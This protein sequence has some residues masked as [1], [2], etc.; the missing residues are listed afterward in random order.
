M[1]RETAVVL[2]GT[3]WVGRHVSASFAAEGYDVVTVARDRAERLPYARFVRL[4]LTAE[5]VEKIVRTLEAERPAV[6]VN[7]AGQPWGSSEEVMRT[8]LL[9]LTER[10]LAALGALPFR[11]RFVQVG[12]VME[13][14]P[15]PRGVPIG[16]NTAPRPAGA[17]G[18]IKLAASTAVLEAARAGR[19]DAVVVRLVNVAGP[20]TAPA[21]LLGRVLEELLTAREE[22]RDAELVLAPLRAQRDYIDIRDAGDAVLAAARGG[23]VGQAVN[24]GSGT[25]VPVRRLVRQLIAA[26]GVPTRLEERAPGAGGPVSP[27]AGG[28]WL[29]VDPD[30]A[31]LLLGW[32]AQ[33]PVEG[34]LSDDWHDRA[35]RRT[36]S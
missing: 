7:A 4:D 3:G 36:G 29:A 12:T 11:P 19:V 17:Y 16:E 24:I 28:D 25:T 21:S 1:G 10:V 15:T 18:R 33:R 26:S 8:S 34:A 6:V 31:R 35:A 32:K 5:P 22:G 9:E 2:G 14:G 27:G 13:Y 23:L 30:P 20:G